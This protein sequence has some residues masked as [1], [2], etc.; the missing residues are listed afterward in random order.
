MLTPQQCAEWQGQ[1]VPYFANCQDATEFCDITDLRPPCEAGS[2]MIVPSRADPEQY[3]LLSTAAVEIEDYAE[4]PQTQ[5]HYA[6][7]GD[8]PWL[9]HRWDE[10][11]DLYEKSICGVA[12]SEDGNLGGCIPEGHGGIICGWQPPCPELV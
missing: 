9:C 6:H 5:H 12:L 8:Q 3:E 10:P 2:W 4:E 11:R 7:V 1:H